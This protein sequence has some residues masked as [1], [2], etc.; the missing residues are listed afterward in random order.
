MALQ[1][2]PG[3]QSPADR[4]KYSDAELEA[5]RLKLGLWRDPDPVPPW[6]YRQAKREHMNDL[7]SFL[8]KSTVR[9]AQ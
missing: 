9:G 1:E 6:E 5:R 7:E 3:E 2:V 8:G 4:V